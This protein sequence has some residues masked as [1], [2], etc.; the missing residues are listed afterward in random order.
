MKLKTLLIITIALLLALVGCSRKTETTQNLV[1]QDKFIDE[2]KTIIEEQSESK[3][4][5]K[6]IRYDQLFS[7]SFKNK[8]LL[9]IHDKN[10]FRRLTNFI[11]LEKTDN[12]YTLK[13]SRNNIENFYFDINGFIVLETKFIGVGTGSCSSS[14][15]VY[16]DDY[17]LVLNKVKKSVDAKYNTDKI[18]Q[19]FATLSINNRELTYHTQNITLDNTT[20]ISFTEN[21]EQ[22]EYDITNCL[23]KQKSPQ[24]NP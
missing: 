3:M 17:K 4:L 6:E 1:S 7:I 14:Y 8:E 16:N 23:F 12:E 15:L 5:L 20:A 10:C 22:F 11:V 19:T 9:I 13:L 24:T 2:I 21:I 18:Y